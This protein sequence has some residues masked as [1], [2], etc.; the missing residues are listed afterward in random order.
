[1]TVERAAMAQFQDN[2]PI[3]RVAFSMEGYTM[4]KDLTGPGERGR[5]SHAGFPLEFFRHA[6]NSSLGRV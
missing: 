6:R 1:M 5:K 2:T 3:H 4:M